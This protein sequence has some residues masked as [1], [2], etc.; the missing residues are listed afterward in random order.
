MV[1]LRHVVLEAADAEVVFVGVGVDGQQEDHVNADAAET[2]AY[3]HPVLQFQLRQ[4]LAFQSADEH[5]CR[6]H[7]E[8]VDNP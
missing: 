1:P 7:Q 3:H 6:P 8:D 5:Q 4:L 2:A